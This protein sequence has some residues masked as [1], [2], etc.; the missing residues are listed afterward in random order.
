MQLLAILMLLSA[1][2]NIVTD[3]QG[4]QDSATPIA[5]MV[6]V[7]PE[8]TLDRQYEPWL[9]VFFSTGVDNPLSESAEWFPRLGEPTVSGRVSYSLE[10]LV[11]GLDADLGLRI[12][13]P[14]EVAN[15]ASLAVSEMELGATWRWPKAGLAAVVYP[16]ARLSVLLGYWRARG[17]G[18]L[19]DDLWFVPGARVALGT[20][21]HLGRLSRRASGEYSGRLF[22]FGE[23]GAIGRLAQRPLL[24]PQDE[25][26]DNP[27][28]T[29]N[30]TRLGQINLSGWFWDLGVGMVF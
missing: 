26:D 4:S 21:V 20:R 10:P 17:N 9:L 5:E 30:P 27:L 29:G 2:E 11:R 3:P 13:R 8:R 25:D 19:G 24:E 1:S 6:A 22:V 28:L 16:Y 7:E 14:D 18:D 15:G 23:V 12:M